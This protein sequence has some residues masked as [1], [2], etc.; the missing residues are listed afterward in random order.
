MK[1]SSA[2]FNETRLSDVEQMAKAAA[3][4]E[5]HH[6]GTPTPPALPVNRARASGNAG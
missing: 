6:Q 5:D 1:A 2:H 4:P 3:L